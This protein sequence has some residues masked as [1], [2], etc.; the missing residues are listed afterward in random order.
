MIDWNLLRCAFG[1]HSLGNILHDDGR[2]QW[3]KVC[4]YCNK[5]VVVPAPKDMHGKEMTPHEWLRDGKYHV[6]EDRQ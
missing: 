6:S 3:I 4:K 1:K 2:R 5:I